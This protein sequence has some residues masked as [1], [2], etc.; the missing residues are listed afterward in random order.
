[1]FENMEGHQ[2]QLSSK[3]MSQVQDSSSNASVFRICSYMPCV[4]VLHVTEQT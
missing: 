2:S 4:E 3:L 1:M